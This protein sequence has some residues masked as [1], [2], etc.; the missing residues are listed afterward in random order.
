MEGRAQRARPHGGPYKAWYIIL[1]L[2]LSANILNCI[3]ETMSNSLYV[4]IGPIDRD[5]TT[6]NVGQKTQPSPN[7]N[8]PMLSSVYSTVP[9]ASF[10][11]SLDQGI[12]PQTQHFDSDIITVNWLVDYDISL[13]YDGLP[14]LPS[15]ITHKLLTELPTD[16][17]LNGLG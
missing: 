16:L 3:G 1:L 6:S 4:L 17:G 9:S 8:Q 5:K 13:P 10:A 12:N 7:Y 14:L 2:T 15:G 11:H